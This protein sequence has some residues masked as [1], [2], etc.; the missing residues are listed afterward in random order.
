MPRATPAASSPRSAPASAPPSPPS[1]APFSDTFWPQSSSKVEL[2]MIEELSNFSVHKNLIAI[3]DCAG[4]ET[5]A[6]TLGRG[7]S[8]HWY[9]VACIRA[10]GHVVP[11]GTRN[12]GGLA[13]SSRGCPVSVAAYRHRYQNGV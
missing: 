1:P 7:D 9:S 12:Q 11:C 10:P 4:G 5:T 2:L 6:R 3:Q 8:R 13:D